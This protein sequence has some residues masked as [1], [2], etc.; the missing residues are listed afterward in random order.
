VKS[1][2][3]F[4]RSRARGAER[5]KRE[6]PL[7]DGDGLR[8]ALQAQQAAGEPRR[9]RL[10]RLD[11]ALRPREVV[12][13]ATDMAWA[14]VRG[15]DL[16]NGPQITARPSVLSRGSRGWVFKS[17]SAASRASAKRPA[18]RAC[19]RVSAAR[20][21]AAKRGHEKDSPRGTASVRHCTL[22]RIGVH[23]STRSRLDARQTRSVERYASR[24]IRLRIALPPLGLRRFC[25]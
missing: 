13:G 5:L 23:D 21:P 12:H 9:S 14:V 6:Q 25:A 11:L 24:R 19:P 8:G 20:G 18:A 22:R 15:L 16:Q 1:P 3:S 10:V 4:S 7:E 2:G 17:V